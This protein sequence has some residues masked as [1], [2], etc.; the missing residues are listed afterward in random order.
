MTRYFLDT[1]F[2]EDGRT[3]DLISVGIVSSDGREYYAQSTEFDHRNASDWVRENVLAHLVTC[4]H[5][6]HYRRHEIAGLY[7]ADRSYHAKY[8]GQCV[9]EQHNR[10]H[11]CC[12]RTREQIKADILTF[13]NIEEYGTPELWGY[14]S[15]YDHV[16]FCQ[17]F[18][19]MMD[20]PAGWPMYTRDIKQW[21]DELD[22]SQ[23]PEQEGTEH[24]ALDD[25]RHNRVMWNHLETIEAKMWKALR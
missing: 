1:E 18:G 13:M 20:L 14:Y 22:V 6:E 12:W 9:D 3:I 19:T 21:A 8:G 4:P 23:L 7:R 11:D 10:I 15:A 16:A 17:L 5:T 24:N 25:A 2:I